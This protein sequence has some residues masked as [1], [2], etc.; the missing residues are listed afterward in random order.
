[1]GFKVNVT[2][3]VYLSVLNS[4]LPL[5]SL[6][7]NHWKLFLFV[8]VSSWSTLVHVID[9]TEEDIFQLSVLFFDFKLQLVL[10]KILAKFDESE[11]IVWVKIRELLVHVLIRFLSK[12]FWV[13]TLIYNE[14]NTSLLNIVLTQHLVYDCFRL[15]VNL[16]DGL[17]LIL[18]AHRVLK[19]IIRKE[20]DCGFRF[21]NFFV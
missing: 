5:K 14:Y 3:D 2:I 18:W 1:M 12:P 11:I 16:V 21:W 9:L 7:K 15:P 6:T 4:F 10:L 20:R 13:K 8:Y 17:S 19:Y